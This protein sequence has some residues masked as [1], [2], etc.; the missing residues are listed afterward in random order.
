[1]D[2]ST[3]ANVLVI[4]DELDICMLLSSILTQNNFHTKYVTSLQDARHFLEQEDPDIIVLDN[5]LPDGRGLDFIS[6]LKEDYARD[7][8]I[9]ISAFDG[10]EENKKAIE[11][12]ALDFIS[13]PF[14]RD[15]IIHTIRK[16]VSTKEEE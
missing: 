4:D 1:M 10:K 5:H 9:M 16:A 2:A 15:D 8:I 3:T 6:V 7:K 11:S 12:G 13:K 14:T